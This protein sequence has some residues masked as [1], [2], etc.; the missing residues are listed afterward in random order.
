MNKH[1]IPSQP[2]AR[3]QVLVQLD[4][5]L[6]ASLDEAAAA[7]GISRSEILRQ[8]AHDW[9][10]DEDEREAERQWLE[11]YRLIPAGAE[12]DDNSAEWDPERTG[13]DKAEGDAAG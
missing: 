9:L 7:L 12:W 11:S 13:P 8:A 4:D 1:V 3:K 10:A 6:V 5:E 2:M